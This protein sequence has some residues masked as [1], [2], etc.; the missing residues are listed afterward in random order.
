MQGLADQWRNVFFQTVQHHTNAAAL[1]EASLKGQ[2]GKW[3]AALT[4]VV[5]DA[6]ASMGWAASAKGHQLDLLPIPRHEYLA[7]DVMAFDAEKKH[8]AGDPGWSWR[9]PTAI[10]ELENSRDD[11]R[12]AYSL[13]KV[14]CVWA[15]LRVVFCYRRAPAEVET[16]VRFLEQEVVAVMGISRRLDLSGRTLVVVGLRGEAE[17]FPYDFFKWWALETNTGTFGQM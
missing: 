5:I 1:K 2:L 7:L 4:E 8:R 16:L 17:T 15:D 12:I 11:R 13:W 14:L 3:T 6:C 9:F 10:M